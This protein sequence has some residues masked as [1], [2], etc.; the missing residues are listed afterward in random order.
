MDLSRR[1][2]CRKS[3]LPVLPLSGFAFAKKLQAYTYWPDC[4]H[5]LSDDTFRVTGMSKT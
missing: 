1:Q 3:G 2:A 4:W 5:P